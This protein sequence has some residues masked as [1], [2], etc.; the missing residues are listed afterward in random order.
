MEDK[1][2]EEIANTLKNS[3]IAASMNDA[4]R[5][6]KEM[7]FTEEK[8]QED[9]QKR[10]DFMDKKREDM[11]RRKLGIKK[12]EVIQEKRGK[13][14]EEKKEDIIQDV[15]EKG[16]VDRKEPVII[17]ENEISNEVEEDD[18]TL[19]EIMQEEAQTVYENKDESQD[20]IEE[21][22]SGN[23]DISVREMNER[24]ES[25]VDLNEMF[26]FTKKTE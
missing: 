13:V 1:K 8:V 22:S 2:F 25:N 11:K 19:N 14:V 15:G 18:S 12:P 26:D 24:T 9:F 3:G 4:I 23:G 17:N 21:D 6:A 20:I 10:S 16:V 7:V 5:M